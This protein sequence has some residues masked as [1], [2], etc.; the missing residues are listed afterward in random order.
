MHNKRLIFSLLYNN[1][2]FALSRN[3]RLQ[4]VGNIDWLQ[5]NFNFAKISF[6]IDELIII[7]VTRGHRNITQFS[8]DLKKIT[9]GCFVPICAGGGLNTIASV[10]QLL[11]S[12][13]DKVLINSSIFE[14]FDFIKDVA[15]SFGEQCIVA[16]IDVKRNSD[17]EY[18]VWSSNGTK[19]QGF[20]RD[21]LQKLDNY[22]IGEIYL[23]SID[24]D[25]TGNGYD[26]NVLNLIPDS[27]NKPIIIAGGVGNS[28]HLAAGLM[29]MRVD[30][31]ATANLFNFIGDG[32]KLA[33]NFIVN[34]KID[35]P[36]WDSDIAKAISLSG[37]QD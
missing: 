36:I 5:N 31:A 33:R 4:D 28:S 11:R 32:L 37:N 19:K 30:G 20:A 15:N 8:D 10:N 9:E 27:I 18:E 34:N 12:G 29:D 6:S 17:G 1:R 24:Q 35:L 22:P 25:G 7:N 16:S 21:W 3:F 14:D 2:S 26:F 23:N 13:A